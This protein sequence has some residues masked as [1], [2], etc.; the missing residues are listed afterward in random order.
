MTVPPFLFIRHGET[1][2]NAE[3][4]LQGDRDIPLNA[5]GRVQAAESGRRAAILLRRSGLAGEAVFVVSPL[6]RTRDTA[7]R[8]RLAMALPACGYALEERLKELSFGSWEGLTW[9]DVKARD[10]EA[11]TRRRRDVWRFVPPDGESYARLADRVRPWLA[12]VTENLVVVSHG[13][14][15]R[16]LMAL[17][18]GVSVTVAPQVDIMQGRV[19]RF[20]R[21]GYTWH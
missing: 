12:S 17:I 7:E 4:R 3:G 19:L 11:I 18:G 10:P 9:P 20:A 6:G 14:V 13:G 5:T 2:W 1:D 21:G 15:A 8:A 16:A